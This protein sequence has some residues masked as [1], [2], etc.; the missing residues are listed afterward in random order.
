MD[1]LGRSYGLGRR[2]TSTARVW[3]S[4]SKG[5][6]GVF[7]VNSRPMIDYFPRDHLQN[8]VT[9]GGFVLQ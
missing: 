9:A 3:I 4:L 6:G 5:E 7:V 2:K 8:E 1:N